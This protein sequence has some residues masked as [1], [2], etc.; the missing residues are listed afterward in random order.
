MF[1]DQGVFAT[2]PVLYVDGFMDAAT[3]P[4]A[5]DPTMQ[6]VIAILALAVNVIVLAIIIKRSVEQ[7]KNPYTNEIFTDLPDFKQAMARAE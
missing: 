7:K 4:T 5:A 1:Q 3:R 6:G 2:I